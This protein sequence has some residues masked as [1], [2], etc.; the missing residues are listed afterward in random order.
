VAEEL[1]ERLAEVFAQRVSDP[2]LRGLTVCGVRISPDLS[3]ARV[4]YRPRPGAEVAEVEAALARA[5][6]FVRR[7]I[8]SGL[9]LRRVPELDFRLDDSLDRAE[10]IEQIL[11]EVAPDALDADAPLAP[12][13]E[14]DGR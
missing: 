7:A 13:E 8:A 9:K 1:R 12:D 5:K 10:R 4:F 6:P 3:F 2:R 14:E 11:R